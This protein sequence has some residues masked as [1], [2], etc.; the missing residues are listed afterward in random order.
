MHGPS[1]VHSL[2]EIPE[3]P[4][5]DGTYYQPGGSYA[6]GTPYFDANGQPEYRVG[7]ARSTSALM[8]EIHDLDEWREASQLGEEFLIALEGQRQQQRMKKTGVAHAFKPTDV[9]GGGKRLNDCEPAKAMM[10]EAKEIAANAE[11]SGT[12][13]EGRIWNVPMPL[14]R[15]CGSCALSCQVAYETNDGMPTGVT[16]FT[17]AKPLDSMG[18]IRIDMAAAMHPA[19]P[20][21]DEA[22]GLRELFKRFQEPAQ[23]E[24]QE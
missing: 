3:M 8:R 9:C 13:N 18:V 7:S 24:D 1:A 20:T 21:E 6:V 16:R 19:K 17:T 4:L 11:A 5:G 2:L 12:S 10:E 14:S 15:A 23:G 22:A